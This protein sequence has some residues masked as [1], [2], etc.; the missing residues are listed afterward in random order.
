MKCV[1]ITQ[2]DASDPHQFSGTPYYLRKA[3]V[4]AGLEVAVCDRLSDPYRNY[5]RVKR[6]V[7]RSLFSRTYLRGLELRVL[8]AYAEQVDR[9]LSKTGCDVLI[10]LMPDP[11]ALLNTNKPIV[12]INDATFANI[13]DFYP[14][15]THLCDETMHAGHK[16]EQSVLG[17]A[18]LSIFSSHW[19]AHS[20]ITDYSVTEEDRVKVIPFGANIES[21]ISDADIGRVVTARGNGVCRLLFIGREWESK[22]GPLAVSVTRSL[23][24]Q[25]LKTELHVVGCTPSEQP[26][27][28]VKVHGFISKRNSVD[29]ARLCDLFR[30]C[31]FLIL[32]TRAE[33]CAVV[34]AEASS[35]GLPSL[36]TNVGGNSTAIRNGHNGQTFGLCD[37][38]DSYSSFICKH[39][40]DW[41]AYEQ[42]AYSSFLESSSRLNWVSFGRRIRELIQDYCF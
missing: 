35:F 18:K 30:S 23:N 39:F 28:Y 38:P 13:V 2:Y 7:Y 36:T 41:K 29:L 9:F 32:P 16:V 17:R 25:G 19:A 20:A 14:Y 22:G 40:N 27:P 26:P 33:C 21:N 24:Q 42:L 6:I 1:L 31:H 11:V 4:G 3:L 15:T 12:Y 34:L 5:Y 8:K 10:S 37:G